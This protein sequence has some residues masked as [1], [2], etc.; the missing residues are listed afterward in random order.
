MEEEQDEG[1][2]RH[3]KEREKKGSVEDKKNG[4]RGD[5]K[6]KKLTRRRKEKSLTW[7]RTDKLGWSGRRQR[8]PFT[9]LRKVATAAHPSLTL[10][11]NTEQEQCGC[12]RTHTQAHARTQ[13]PRSVLHRS[14]GSFQPT[15]LRDLSGTERNRSQ[16]ETPPPPPIPMSEMMDACLTQRPQ[17]AVSRDQTIQLYDKHSV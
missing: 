6:E 2:R 8:R 7:I 10:L 12:A 9:R 11:R 13:S 14:A 16:I 5:E 4:S 3:E 1:R 15:A 17:L